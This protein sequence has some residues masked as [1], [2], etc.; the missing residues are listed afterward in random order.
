MVELASHMKWLV[1]ST[2]PLLGSTLGGEGRGVG[3]SMLLM[4]MTSAASSLVHEATNAPRRGFA[5]VR[6]VAQAVLTLGRPR[7]SDV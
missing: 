1:M 3:S 4:D 6:E 7:P 2:I 5:P